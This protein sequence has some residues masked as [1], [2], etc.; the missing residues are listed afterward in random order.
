VL[1]E[2]LDE[3]V[4]AV[5]RATG[6]VVGGQAAGQDEGVGGLTDDRL[7]VGVELGGPE[8]VQQGEHARVR[9][10]A[11]GGHVIRN[12]TSGRRLRVGRITVLTHCQ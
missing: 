3:V 12:G 7:L 11:V 2:A 6:L 9:A 5:Q 1:D 4:E 10:G 8:G